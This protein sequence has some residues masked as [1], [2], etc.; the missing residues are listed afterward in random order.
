MY[1]YNKQIEAFHEDKVRL[2]NGMLER[3]V[4][5]RAANE[6]R[7]IKRLPELKEGVRIGRSSFRS[8]GSF[9]I[10]TVIQTKFADEEYDIDDGVVLWRDDL[11][12]EEGDDMAAPDAKELVKQALEDDRFKT[13]PI[14]KTNCVRVFYAEEDEDKHHVDFPVYRKY[15][16]GEGDSAKTIRELASD[17][18]WVESDPTRVNVWFEGEVQ[19][20]NDRRADAGS[21]LRVLIRLLKRFCRSRSDWDMPNGMKLTMLAVECSSY[22]DRIDEAFRGLLQK[23]KD[24]LL[25]SLEVDNLADENVPKAKLTKTTAD[26]NMVELRNRVEEALGKIEVLDDDDCTKKDAR[27]AWDWVFKSDGFFDEYDD[28]D[29]DGGDGGGS[30]DGSGLKKGI[31]VTTPKQPVDPKGGGRFG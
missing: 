15:D 31:A 5:H 7:L 26:A 11:K 18:D 8:Q 27:Q 22:C 1:D 16:E 29:D 30:G 21:Q 20:R 17:S 24:R 28:D 23:L 3:L 2:S 4:G 13:Q 9:A 12:D 14:T 25:V 10:K 19:T 6:D